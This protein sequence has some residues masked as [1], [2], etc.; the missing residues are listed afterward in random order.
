MILCNF[1]FV[2]FNLTLALFS[3]IPSKLPISLCDIPAWESL[4]ISGFVFS[5]LKK[6]I[7]VFMATLYI[8][9]EKE[10]LPSKL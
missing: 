3:V 1:S 6:V 7:A 9:V 5:F 10:L 4:T 2:L 8:H